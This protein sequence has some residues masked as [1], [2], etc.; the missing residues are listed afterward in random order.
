MSKVKTLIDVLF[1]KEK[2]DV[3]ELMQIRREIRSLVRKSLP[4]KLIAHKRDTFANGFSSAVEI[5]EKE[6]KRRG[7]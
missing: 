7:L 4:K 3:K 5:F 6:L 2:C 1:F